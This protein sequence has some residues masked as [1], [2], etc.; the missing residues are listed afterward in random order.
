MQSHSRN[1]SPY[2]LLPNAIAKMPWL[3]CKPFFRKDT[4][5]L[6]S[7]GKRYK[8]FFN[9]DI[10]LMVWNTT[11]SMF[12]PLAG[13]EENRQFCFFFSKF[14]SSDR[15]LKQQ[16]TTGNSFEAINNE[17]NCEN[18][19]CKHR[20]LLS[21]IE[22]LKKKSKKLAKICLAKVLSGELV[23]LGQKSGQTA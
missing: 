9:S 2:D 6:K 16:N 21:F 8:Q 20:G 11:K 23:K 3:I 19:S 18:A 10:T 5:Y 4:N 17:I 15:V 14:D 7:F 12:S 1:Q 22:V 13:K